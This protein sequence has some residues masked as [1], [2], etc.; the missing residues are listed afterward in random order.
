MTPTLTQEG[1]WTHTRMIDELPPESRVELIDNELYHMPMPTL[2]H[3]DASVNLHFAMLTF[4]R[5]HQLGRVYAAPLPTIL[6]ENVVV[7]PDI[8][9]ISKERFDFSKKY[10]YEAPDL[11]VEIISPSSVVRDSVIKKD[12]YEAHG[13]REY[14]LLDPANR[15]IEVFVLEANRYRLD[16][17]AQEKG[18]ARS[19]VLP[20]F[21][22]QAEA[23]F[24]S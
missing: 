14:W 9:F 7:E 13:V 19:V 2:Q 6:A 21:E 10:V 15:A 1:I 16:N 18:P 22:V 11:V 17:Y 4:V 24:E 5:Q 3:Q 8:L 23:I 20:G 12:L